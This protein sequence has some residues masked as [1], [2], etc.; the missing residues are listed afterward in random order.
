MVTFIS[1][2][3]R[4]EHRGNRFKHIP[5]SQSKERTRLDPARSSEPSRG[6]PSRDQQPSPNWSAVRETN[7]GHGCAPLRV[8]GCL[9]LSDYSLIKPY[10]SSPLFLHNF[11]HTYTQKKKKTLDIFLTRMG[12][13][14]DKHTVII[15]I[16][17]NKRFFLHLMFKFM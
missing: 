9:L 12:S 15:L 1:S 3:P 10:A 16:S 7:K 8:C 13:L 11:S 6:E 5:G 14:I 2:V 17:P 4:N